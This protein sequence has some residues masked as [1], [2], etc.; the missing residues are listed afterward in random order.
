MENNLK[1]CAYSTERKISITGLFRRFSS[2]R[3]EKIPF[4]NGKADVCIKAAATSV[5]Y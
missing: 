5:Y 3:R 2:Q 4:G 1:Y